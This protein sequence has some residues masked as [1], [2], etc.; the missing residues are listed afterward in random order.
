VTGYDPEFRG[1]GGEADLARARQ[2]LAEAGYPEG[3]DPAT[4]RPLR[5]RFDQGGTDLV[6]RRQAELLAQDFRRLGIDLEP[7]M[8]NWPRFL[9]KLRQGDIQLF[10]MAWVA[11]YPDAQN[12]LQ[13]FYGANLGSANRTAYRNPAFDRLY[14]QAAVLPEGPARAALYARL[15][16]LVMADAPCLVESFPVSHRLIQP[17]VSG[18]RAH[19]FAWDAW[20]YLGADDLQR[21]AARRQ[22]VPLAVH[23]QTAP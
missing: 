11:D 7:A 22:A 10:R 12:F 18:C 5:L 1:P 8:H 15:Q 13:L 9:D 4:G 17:W 2:L 14:E 21:Q 6:R 16:A 20:K 19:A 23:L 3:R